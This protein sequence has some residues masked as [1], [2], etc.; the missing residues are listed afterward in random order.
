MSTLNQFAALAD[1][2]PFSKEVDFSKEFEN[3]PIRSIKETPNNQ[4]KEDPDLPKRVFIGNILIDKDLEDAKTIARK[5]GSIKHATRPFPSKA[6]N[7][8]FAFITMESHE[9]AKHLISVIGNDAWEDEVDYQIP[10]M[11]ADWARDTKPENPNLP[12]RLF[13]GNLES[14]DELNKVKRKA[15]RIGAIE[16][17]SKLFKTKRD[18]VNFAF[19]TMSTHKAAAD[20]IIIIGDEPYEEDFIYGFDWIKMVKIR[21]VYAD[22]AKEKPSK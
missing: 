11:Y 10:H 18:G 13:I 17:T 2:D 15:A 16:H 22:W 12:R 19:L 4:P 8:F 21:K 1:E 14:L 5:F 20:L 3:I 6:R 7:C 9:A